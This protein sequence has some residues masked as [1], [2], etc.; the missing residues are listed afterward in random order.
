[1]ALNNGTAIG[2][3]SGLVGLV[4]TCSNPNY[5]SRDLLRP[6]RV[7]TKY[8]HYG[9]TSYLVGYALFIGGTLGTAFNILT[10]NAAARRRK[11]E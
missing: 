6:D 5:E 7:I 8:D 4:M 11:E 9:G 3:I 10:G 2:V 1:M